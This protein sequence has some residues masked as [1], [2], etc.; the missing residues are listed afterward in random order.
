[1]LWIVDCGLLIIVDMWCWSE[2]SASHR[3]SWLK[4]RVERSLDFDF[5]TTIGIA[6]RAAGLGR[7]GLSRVGFGPGSSCPVVEGRSRDDQSVGAH[8]SGLLAYNFCCAV[9]WCA[10]NVS[11]PV[12]LH[13]HTEHK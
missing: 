12:G 1:M 2:V 5:R 7:S 13:S 11:H 4:V 3:H 9:Q 6:R 10:A 8:R